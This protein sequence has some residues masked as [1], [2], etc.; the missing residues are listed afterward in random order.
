M[1]DGPIVISSGPLMTPESVMGRS[2]TSA[3]R[4]YHTAEVRQFLK[5]V[6]EELTAGEKRESELRQALDEALERIAHPD[7]DEATVTAFLGD[8]AT[9]LMATARETAALITAEAEQQAA[10]VV[11]AAEDRAAR[12][13]EEAAGVLAHRVS[14]AN[15]VTADVHQ[16]AVTDIDVLRDQARADAEAVISAARDEGRAMVG[17]ARAVRERMLADLARRRRSGEV[18]VEQLRAA[19]ERLLAAYDVVRRTLDEATA[20]LTV[21][22]SDAAGAAGA[23]GRRQ[24]DHPARKPYTR[25]DSA[26]VGR[27]SQSRVPGRVMTSPPSGAATAAP[28]DRTLAPLED[29]PRPAGSSGRPFDHAADLGVGA[30]APRPP[31]NRSAGRR[32]S[33]PDRPPMRPQTVAEIAGRPAAVARPDVPVVALPAVLPPAPPVPKAVA[34]PPAPAAP[35][36][37]ALAQPHVADPPVVVPPITSAGAA[38]SPV[39]AERALVGRDDLVHTVEA[40]LTRAL[41]R[42][43][44]NEQNAVLDGLRRLGPSDA[45]L[46]DPEA[47]VAAYRDAAVPWLHMAARVGVEQGPDPAAR[48][49]GDVAHPPLEAQVGSLAAELVDPLRERVLRAMLDAAGSEDP[50]VVGETLRAVYRQWKVQRIEECARHHIVAAFTLG[51]FAAMPADAVLQWLVDDNGPC[52]DCDDNAL[53]GPTP[54]GQAFPTGQLYPPAHRGC[55]CM[56][57]PATA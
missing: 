28:S 49:D 56:L 18:Q 3:F 24:T 48:S 38:P 17:E 57:V 20:E 8:H 53:A 47:H 36:A 22:E 7:L 4:G 52:P 44:Q 23:D 21:A 41:K 15:A 10:T 39:V 50:T 46:P 6:S 37:V 29:R 32:P 30:E 11:A 13:L 12:M 35:P 54:K 1:G 34:T 9:R 2:F 42:V 16:S 55:R 43:L 26:S 5:R 19:R 51:T 27:P 45:V 31:A 33:L 14:E 25:A 40:G